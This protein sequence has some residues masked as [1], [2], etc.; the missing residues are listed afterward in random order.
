M[1]DTLYIMPDG[2][3]ATQGGA[4]VLLDQADFEDCCCGSA[5]CDVCQEAQTS[6]MTLTVT[7]DCTDQGDCEDAAVVGL[8]YESKGTVGDSYCYWY[9]LTIEPQRHVLVQYYPSTGTWLASAESGSGLGISS[10]ARNPITGLTCNAGGQLSGSFSLDG[11]D[12]SGDG[13]YDCS[14]CTLTCT[15]VPT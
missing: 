11:I 9:W 14:G 7:G 15:I 2:T 5:P 6:T 4:P 8:P 1:V 13:L 3:V 10:W 12:S